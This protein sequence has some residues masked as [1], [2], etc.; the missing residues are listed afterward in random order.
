MELAGEVEKLAK[1]LHPRNEEAAE[2]HA[3]DT[4]LGA[5]ERPLAAEVQ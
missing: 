5:L 1:Q 3:T 2:R 4:F